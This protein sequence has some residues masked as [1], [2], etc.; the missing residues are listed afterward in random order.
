MVHPVAETIDAKRTRILAGA[1]A[2]PR[3]H[4]DGRI[5]ALQPTIYT[6]IHQ[7]TKIH[8]ALI[9][10]NDFGRGAVESENANLHFRVRMFLP[11]SGEPEPLNNSGLWAR[12][13]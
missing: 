4:G 13:Q 8:Q 12:G 6:G 7:T 5:H 3:R 10:E 11:S 1:H 2:H 9:T